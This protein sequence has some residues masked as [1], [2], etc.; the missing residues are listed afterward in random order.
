MNNVCYNTS[1]DYA[2]RRLKKMLISDRIGCDP[3]LFDSIQKELGQIISG[4]MDIDSEKIH[5][6]VSDNADLSEQI[7]EDTKGKTVVYASI[8]VNNYKRG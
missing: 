1:G 8:P 7:K 2:I 4:Y 3:G 6:W 5:V